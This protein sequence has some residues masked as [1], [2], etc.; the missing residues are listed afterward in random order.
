[1]NHTIK[2]NFAKNL[3]EKLISK[4][5]KQDFYIKCYKNSIFQKF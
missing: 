5:F 2:I 4:N 3:I 1:M